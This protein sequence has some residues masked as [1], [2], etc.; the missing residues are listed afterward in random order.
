MSKDK[1]R[2]GMSALI[3]HPEQK[4]IEE[5]MQIFAS[6]GFQSFF[7][8]C[9]VTEQF[10]K[11]PFWSKHAQNIGID[12]EAVHAPSAMVD[13]VWG[14]GEQALIYKKTTERILD[15]CSDGAVAKLVLHVGSLPAT[16]VTEAGLAFWEY[17]EEYARKRGVKLCYENANTP[18]LFEAVVSRVQDFHGV[19]FDVGHQL[20]YTPEKDYAALYGEKLLYTHIHDNLADGRD[21]HL[22][23]KDG[24]N[25]WEHYFAQLNEVQYTGTFNL[26]LSCYFC[27]AYRDMT[28]YDFAA[29]C[30]KRLIALTKSQF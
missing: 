16:K 6:V 21:M 26:E 24:I 27:Q 4:S 17:L 22:L 11:I 7:L 1:N 28:F 9:G 12:F 3:S 29:H 25:N 13:S 23:P 18:V 2:L 8:S 20:C 19:C 30:C 15:F 5:Q 14:G 10:E